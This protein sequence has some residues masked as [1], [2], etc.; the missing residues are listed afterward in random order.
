MTQI[1]S[2]KELTD[3]IPEGMKQA[4]PL[5]IRLLRQE[6]GQPWEMK[7]KLNLLQRLFQEP[8]D[9]EYLLR[10]DEASPILSE[11][12]PRYL[13]ALTLAYEKYQEDLK[14]L[15]YR[16]APSQPMFAKEAVVPQQVINKRTPM[17]SFY[18][19]AMP[20]ATLAFLVITYNA[21]AF[22]G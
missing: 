11:Q 20:A 15:Q 22:G 14:N 18:E 6:V 16:G 7:S 4:I 17:D 19:H 8:W 1:Q 2:I 3:E 5:Y 21:S 10:T 13:E 9:I 12:M